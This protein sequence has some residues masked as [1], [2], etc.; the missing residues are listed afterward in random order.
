[1]KKEEREIS[2]IPKISAARRGDNNVRDK[3]DLWITEHREGRKKNPPPGRRK[4]LDLW[5][6]PQAGDKGRDWGLAPL[7]PV[8]MA[9]LWPFCT[10]DVRLLFD[11]C[12]ITDRTTIEHQSNINRTSMEQDLSKCAMTFPEIA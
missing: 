1:M 12:S 11:C 3:L 8:Q 5:I 4:E 7:P 10:I 6:T 9:V 2:K